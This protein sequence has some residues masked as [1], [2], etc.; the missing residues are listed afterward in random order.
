MQ[1]KTDVHQSIA[2]L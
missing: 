1:D 2:E